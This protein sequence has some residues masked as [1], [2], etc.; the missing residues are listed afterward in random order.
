MSSSLFQNS[1][2]LS[3]SDLTAQLRELVEGCFPSVWVAGE[4]SNFTRASSGHWYFTLK[5]SKAQLRAV[6]WRGFNLRIRFDPK[7]GLEVFARGKVS[8][9]EQRGECQLVVEEIQPKGIGAAELALRQ[10][11]EKLLAQGYFDPRRKRPLPRFPKRV[12]IITSASGAAI[13]DMVELFAQRWPLT[14]LIITPSRV[15]GEGAAS[16]VAAAVRMLN[17][18]HANG[19]LTLD[20]IILGRG[21]GSIEDLWA[22]NEEVI[23]DAIFASE[24]PVVSAV[25]HEV[26]VTIADLVADHRA[27]TPSAAVV[28]LTPNRREMSSGFLELHARLS[29][30]VNHRL[31]LARHR[32]EQLASRPAFRQPIQRIRDLEQRLDNSAERLNRVINQRVVQS[33][34]RIASLAARLESLSPLNVL[35][36]GYSLTHKASGELVRSAVEV[37]PGELLRTRVAFGEIFSR[38]EEAGDSKLNK[39][40]PT[41]GTGSSKEVLS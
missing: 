17:H 9:Y 14:E 2:P 26:D 27:E 20:A 11:K 40:K 32:V 33:S 30:A 4:I 24:V 34:E 21:G 37:A 5:D 10:L 23:A 25:G 3:V 1:E 6:M 31:Q 8:F 19:K 12:G 16:E 41:D 35:T 18:L 36:R 22:F 15:Q 28:A 29:E 13:R 39:T 38:V 7:D